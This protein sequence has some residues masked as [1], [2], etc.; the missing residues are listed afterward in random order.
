MISIKICISW[1]YNQS[2]R[3]IFVA[4]EGKWLFAM[5]KYITNHHRV[6]THQKMEYIAGNNEAD[7]GFVSLKPII[8]DLYSI[9]R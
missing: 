8:M 7:Q 1:D 9:G 3:V 4:I 5:A 6:H 2:W